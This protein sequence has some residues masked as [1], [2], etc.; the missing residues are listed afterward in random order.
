[1]N[2]LGRAPGPSNLVDDRLDLTYAPCNEPYMRAG[3][4]QHLCNRRAD[5]SA[6][7]G[8]EGIAALR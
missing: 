8:D 5:S 2:G 3:R 6:S 1:M 4:R 7:T